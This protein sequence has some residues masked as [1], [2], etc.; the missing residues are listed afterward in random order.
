MF[1]SAGW[2]CCALGLYTVKYSH[3]TPSSQEKW[4]ILTKQQRKGKYSLSESAPG[5]NGTRSLGGAAPGADLGGSSKLKCLHLT[6]HNT[7]LKCDFKILFF[8]QVL[9]ETF[10]FCSYQVFFFFCMNIL[11]GGPAKSEM[12]LQRTRLCLKTQVLFYHVTAVYLLQ[13]SFCSVYTDINN[14][15]YL[16]SAL[17]SIKQRERSGGE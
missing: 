9:R 13:C 12:L 11:C 2:V 6:K 14:G 5:V 4:W 17:C 15:L 7:F 16:Y 1:T 3:W 8:L 10:T